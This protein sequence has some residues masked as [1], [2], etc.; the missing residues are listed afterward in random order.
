MNLILEGELTEIKNGQ[1][2]KVEAN[3]TLKNS[4]DYF[5]DLHYLLWLR[6][7]NVLIN[8]QNTGNEQHQ[9]FQLSSLC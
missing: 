2:R 5:L 9:N 1:L 7:V 6:Y 4:Q 3:Y 8:I